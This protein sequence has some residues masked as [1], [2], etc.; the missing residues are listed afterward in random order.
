MTAPQLAGRAHETR[1][2]LQLLDTVALLVEL[3]GT[4]LTG[5]AV[6][7]F[8]GAVGVVVELLDGAAVLV[9]FADLEG[10]AYATAFVDISRLLRLHHGDPGA[11]SATGRD[12]VAPLV[13]AKFVSR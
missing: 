9:E 4:S 10:V 1:P 3:Q 11:P 2:E 13:V 8:P 5:E 12:G 6:S 7:L